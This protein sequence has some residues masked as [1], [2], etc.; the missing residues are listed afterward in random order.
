MTGH[1]MPTFLRQLPYPS[2]MYILHVVCF[3]AVFLGGS[4][5]NCHKFIAWVTGCGQSTICS[6]AEQMRMTGGDREP[7]EHGLRKYYQKLHPH[8]RRNSEEEEGQEDRRD[9]TG[10]VYELKGLNWESFWFLILTI[11]L[12]KLF[13][14]IAITIAILSFNFV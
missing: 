13:F 6:V 10:I 7:P 3:I 5:P 8:R 12:S 9:S 11:L 2:V 4:R 1:L 14:P